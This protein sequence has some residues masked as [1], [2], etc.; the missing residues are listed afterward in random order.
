MSEAFNTQ[1]AILNASFARRGI[2]MFEGRGLL[3]ILLIGLI[4]GWLAGKI[5]TGRGFG[6]I[7]DIVVGIVGAFVGAWIFRHLGI[8]IGPG[9]ISAIVSATV[10]AVVLLGVIRLIKHA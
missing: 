3:A 5:V 9:L 8:F 1:S 2:E 6:V 10:G 7:A 4:A